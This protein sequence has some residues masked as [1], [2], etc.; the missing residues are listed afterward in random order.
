MCSKDV[1][2]V[3]RWR[4]STICLNSF[5]FWGAF[6]FDKTIDLDYY[7]SNQ[8]SFSMISMVAME[9]AILSIMSINQNKHTH[10]YLIASLIISILKIIEL[11]LDNFVVKFLNPFFGFQKYVHWIW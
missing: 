4:D 2:M 9:Y 8:S 6:V 1:A 5:Y 10:S 11:D 3:L 7:V